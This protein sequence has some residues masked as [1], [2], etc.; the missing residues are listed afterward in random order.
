MSLKSFLCRLGVTN[1][2]SE[3]TGLCGSTPWC[4]LEYDG[5]LAT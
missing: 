2:I 3:D 1:A 4:F 5:L